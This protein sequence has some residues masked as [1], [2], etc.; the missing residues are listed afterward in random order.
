M[1][2][3]DH[4]QGTSRTILPIR[5]A[6]IDDHPAIVASIAAA[7]EAE[8]A[9]RSPERRRTSMSDRPARS[10]AAAR[11]DV[12]LLD[13]QLEGGA[14]G[15]RLPRADQRSGRAGGDR[16]R[17]AVIIVS[18]FDQPSLMRAA[19]ERGAAGYL[20][21][22][23][24]VAEILEAVRTVWS[25]GT[26]FTA[27]AV[28]SV[29]RPP[30]G[31][32]TARSSA[33][34]LIGAGASTRRRRSAAGLSE[35]TIESHLRRLFDR[36]GVL[37]RTELAVLAIDERWITLRRDQSMTRHW[38]LA[39]AG[40][41]GPGPDRRG[42]PGRPVRRRR[43]SAPPQDLFRRWWLP[44]DC[45][46][47]GCSVVE[48]SPALGLPRLPRYR[49]HVVHRRLG[50]GWPSESQDADWMLLVATVCAGALFATGSAVR[51]ATEPSRVPAHWVRPLGVIVMAVVVATCG[52][53]IV[54]AND[55]SSSDRAAR[56]HGFV[57]RA[58]LAVVSRSWCWG[59]SVTFDPPG[60]ERLPA[61]ADR[62][63]TSGGFLGTVELARDAARIFV[64]EIAPGGQRARR[65]AGI[66]RSRIA[67]ELHADVIPVVR[68]AL[69]EAEQGGSPERL[70][71]ALRDVLVPGRW[72]GARSESI[73]LDEL[74]LLRHR[75][76]R[77][78]HRGTLGRADQHRCARALGHRHA[79]P[80]GLDGRPPR[81]VEAAAY[82]VV[83]LALENVV[84]HAP[85]STA[86]IQ[87]TAEPD[88]VRISIRDDGPGLHAEAGP[89]AVA[90]GRRGLADMRA[91]AAGCGASLLAGT[92]QG[93][94]GTVIR[95][96]WPLD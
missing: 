89:L 46:S 3:A 91:A 54:T 71:V 33:L 76:A 29:R 15:L 18:G 37:S 42:L 28:R 78:A 16:D 69:R 24:S 85:A 83:Q 61:S 79:G 30:A 34:G 53:A 26:A 75:V 58:L 60:D 13:I 38:A 96:A 45:A 95:F 70:V 65:A 93:G 87:L 92:D 32:P 39:V 20:V 62:P 8:P 77:G 49:R 72:P 82:L 40:L 74:G 51:Y 2:E 11:I 81:D 44:P 17:P 57:T 64:D 21:K 52:W 19:F 27:A 35:K 90:S 55:G 48:V 36:Y 6:I 67:V 80:A 43:G 25:G 31:R 63:A 1:R 23:A 68:R 88:R 41:A 86:S 47:P 7:V 4:A 14:E 22:T 50:P 10:I 5:V 84:R 73:A 66:E 94:V 9:W 12:V 59:S 56:E